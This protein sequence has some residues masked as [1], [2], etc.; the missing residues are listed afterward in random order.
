MSVDT[1]AFM[2]RSV[3]WFY[4]GFHRG[5]TDDFIGNGVR[6]FIFADISTSWSRIKI[7]SSLHASSSSTVNI[8]DDAN[9]RWNR[10]N[11]SLMSHGRAKC[12]NEI[13]H[14]KPGIW[15][16]DETDT[17]TLNDFKW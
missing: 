4:V 6:R 7:P 11:D 3:V 9:D 14:P 17:A 15:F 12:E 1:V 5:G 8:H 10:H 16:R 13:N 2:G